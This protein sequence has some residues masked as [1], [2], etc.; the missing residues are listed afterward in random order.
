ME[1]LSNDS[2]LWTIHGAVSIQEGDFYF[3][4]VFLQFDTIMEQAPLFARVIFH[5]CCITSSVDSV[6]SSIHK[7]HQEQV[8]I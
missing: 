8:E 6:Q 4:C 3:D 5:K 7:T 1:N 2:Q